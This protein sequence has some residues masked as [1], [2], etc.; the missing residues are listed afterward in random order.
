MNFALW[1]HEQ[2]IPA[3][4]CNGHQ[5][6]HALEVVGRQIGITSR[7]GFHQSFV[8]LCAESLLASLV[9]SQLPESKSQLE[10]L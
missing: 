3:D 9:L 6:R 7:L 1:R 2:T 5:I 4:L 8:D 10:N